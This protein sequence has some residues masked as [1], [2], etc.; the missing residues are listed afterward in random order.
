MPHNLTIAQ[1]KLHVDWCKEMLKKND[2]GAS[3]D[4]HK[5]VT[6][7][8]TGICAYEPETKQQSTVWVL[9]HEPNA[10]KVVCEKSIRIVVCFLCKTDHVA[11]VPL[12]HRRPVVCPK[13]SKKFEKR[14]TE[15]EL[16]FSIAMRAVCCGARG[17][18]LASHTD[19]RGFAPQCGGRLSSLT[20]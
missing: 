3:K 19:V 4:V 5:I 10:T 12:E 13:S 17:R 16:L 2:G 20:C 18:A 9:E 1:K 8:E 7:D 6:A 11:A 15:E 14:T